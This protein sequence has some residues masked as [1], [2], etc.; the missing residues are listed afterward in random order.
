MTKG[1]FCAPIWMVVPLIAMGSTAQTQI[2]TGA[3]T[4]VTLDNYNLQ[5]AQM[6]RHALPFRARKDSATARRLD[7]AATV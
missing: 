1:K 4:S 6:A 2:L 3:A 5:V 7:A